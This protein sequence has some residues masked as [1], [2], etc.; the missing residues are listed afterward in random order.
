MTKSG[1]AAMAYNRYN[2]RM[3]RFLAKGLLSL[4]FVAL[5]G[6]VVTLRPTPAQG[7]VFPGNNGLIAYTCGTNICTFDPSSSIKNSA[8][9]GGATDPS[10]SSD[11]TE[12][13][14]L[15]SDPTM[16]ITVANAD[17]TGPVSLAAPASSTQPTFSFDGDR[18]AYVRGGNIYTISN[19]FGGE[20]PLTAAGTDA[21]PA[22]SPDGS[23]IAFARNDGG[24]AG[25]DIWTIDISTG[26]LHQVTNAVGNE[27]NPTWSKS[28]LTIVYSADLGGATP[29]L[30]ASASSG[31][32]NPTP[33][34]LGVQ[35]TDPAYSP[36]GTK[37]AFIT[38][39]GGLSMMVA[40]QNGAVTPLDTSAGNSDPDWQAISAPSSTGGP[41]VN[42]SYPTVN[43]TFGDTQPTL[44]DFLTAGIGSWTG[45]FPIT[46]TYQWKR[47][48]AA[49][50]LN[51][52]CTD[53]LNAHSSF[54]TPVTA[55]YGERLRVQVTATNS[56]GAVSQ[57]S[58]STAPVSADAVV[59]R[60]TPQIF[61]DNIVDGTLTLTPG[62][63]DGSN[64]LTFTYSWRRCNAAGDLG[65]CV[66]IPGATLS[67]YTPT[68]ADIG[69]SIRVWITGTN[70]T[71]SAIAVT[72]HTFPVVDKQHFSPSTVA[73]PAIVGTLAIGRQLTGSIGTFDGD[74]PIATKFVWQRCDATGAACH[75]I[76]GATKV[77]YH[78]STDDLGSTL[79][80]AVTAT[81]AYGT[82]VAMSDPTEPVLASPPH[83]KGR[84]IVGTARG[85]YLAGGGFDDSIFGMGGNDT[86]MGGAGDDHLD[87]GAGND[88]ITGG[89]G[90]D[91]IFGGAGS[92]TI[93]AADGE[94]DVID[95][96]AGRDRAVVDSVDIVKNC[97][98]VVTST[99]TGT[100]PSPSPS[101]GTGAGNPTGPGT[102]DTPPG[103]TTNP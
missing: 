94:R 4:A 55:D 15:S 10:W 24:T 25:Y 18:V 68:V 64:P 78:P 90:A 22:Y 48:D 8:F 59:L 32:S 39:G 101:P 91:T 11:E 61:G 14:Y 56:Q 7:G 92:D 45:A 1:L 77:I 37:I 97:E 86:I 51:G 75:T 88:V 38:T 57:N 96:G 16:G 89:S 66:Q 46:Y 85:E 40:A 49:D 100:G 65:S 20:L 21:D 30:Y 23:Q 26:V 83:R 74:T 13:A 19:G 79:R 12:I 70:I 34:S 33:V 98:V 29:A 54:Y 28:G 99:S 62:T 53:I 76:V 42:V 6:G 84:R 36:D 103:T 71:G 82:L 81:N 5:A 102:G 50:P 41:P 60:V 31:A 52:Q 44:G 69:S 67:S 3:R 63:W 87:G 17:G 27:R 95:C 73:A 47:C 80:L 35:G 2:V 72:N 9:I 58:E 93:Y 43:H